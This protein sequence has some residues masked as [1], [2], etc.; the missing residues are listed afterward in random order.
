MNDDEHWAITLYKRYVELYGE[1]IEQP[2]E[3]RC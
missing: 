3:S 1:P 2:I